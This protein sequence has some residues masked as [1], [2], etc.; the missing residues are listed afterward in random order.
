MLA[1]ETWLI[2]RA[3]SLRVCGGSDEYAPD[4][5]DKDTFTH[6]PVGVL[7]VLKDLTGKW[8]W[9]TAV[10]QIAAALHNR[11][12]DN[13]FTITELLNQITQQRRKVDFQVHQIVLKKTGHDTDRCE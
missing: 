13:L 11:V 12:S 3:A 1:W 10:Y 8:Y 6:V 4:E 2:G 5:K 7:Q 9:L